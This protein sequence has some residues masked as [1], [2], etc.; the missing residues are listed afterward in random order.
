MRLSKQQLDA[1]G[2][3]LGVTSGICGVLIA[4]HI[5]NENV[6][7]TIGGIATVLLGYIVQR[8][9]AKNY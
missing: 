9:A 4:N 2:T 7:G 1:L 6:I 5:G 8:P 3:F